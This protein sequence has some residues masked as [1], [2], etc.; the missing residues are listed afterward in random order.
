MTAWSGR[1]CL[2]L[3]VQIFSASSRREREMSR[4]NE[5]RFPRVSLG[6]PS[7]SI[8]SDLRSSIWLGLVGR[9]QMT[10]DSQ[11]VTDA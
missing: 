11:L 6:G 1:L 2:S 3:G 10:E 4:D 9:D 8:L 5:V 7:T